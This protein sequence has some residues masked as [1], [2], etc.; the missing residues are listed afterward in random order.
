[1]GYFWDIQLLI[2]GGLHDPIPL[3]LH[4]YWNNHVG[5]IY[6]KLTL[7]YSINEGKK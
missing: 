7:G 5:M 2:V 4:V 3:I 1:M 6:V